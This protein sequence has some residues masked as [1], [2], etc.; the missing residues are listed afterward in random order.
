MLLGEL[1]N[2][3]GKNTGVAGVIT[4][5]GDWGGAPA[6]MEYAEQGR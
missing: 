3:L 1:P 2:A 4:P 5:R 6:R